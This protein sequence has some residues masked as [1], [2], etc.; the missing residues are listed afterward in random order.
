M[1]RTLRA[2]LVATILV[3][4]CG[5]DSGSEGTPD[6]GGTGGGPDAA[7]I[8]TGIDAPPLQWTFIEIEGSRCMNDTATGIGVNINP[9]SRELLVYLEGGGACFNQF[10]CQGVAHQDGFGEATFNQIANDF[11][12]RGL[13]NRNAETNPFRDHSYVFVPYCTGDIHAGSA[14]QGFGGRVQVGYLNM[15]LYLDRLVPAFQGATSVV[16]AGSSAGGFGALYN[17]DR[18]QEAFGDIPVSLVDDSGPPMSTDYLTACL[19]D[20]VWDTWDLE[21]SIPADCTDCTTEAGGLVNSMGFLADKYPDNRFGLISSLEDG[22]IRLF[23]G[24]GYPSCANPQV[25]MDAA[26]FTAGL[27]ELADEILAPHENFRVFY[28]EGGLHVWLFD[29]PLS[30]VEVDGTT[31]DTWLRALITGEGTFENVRPAQ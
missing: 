15:G 30:S 17:F 19:Q 14:E 11:G 9:D 13:F 7:P 2:C 23:Y 24:M 3:S 27:D 5:G 29:E 4:A 18:V 25:P 8:G 1:D 6:G 20:L 21:A 22:T 12:S 26:A 28:L 10:T 31:L 16:L